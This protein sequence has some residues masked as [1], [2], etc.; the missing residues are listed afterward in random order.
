MRFFSEFLVNENSFGASCF[1]GFSAYGVETLDILNP[2][3]NV[4]FP[5]LPDSRIPAPFFSTFPHL[6]F[7]GAPVRIN[8]EKF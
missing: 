1:P 7:F 5:V 2:F 6:N 8:F 4:C 3:L